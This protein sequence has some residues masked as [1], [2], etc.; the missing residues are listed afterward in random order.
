MRTR[1][2]IPRRTASTSPRWASRRRWP[3]EEVYKLLPFVIFND[4]GSGVGGTANYNTFQ[5]ASEN[6]DASASIT[7]VH[8]QARDL[9]RL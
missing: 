9:S 5:Y 7:K 4:N 1:A 3:R 8:G 2:A 6:N